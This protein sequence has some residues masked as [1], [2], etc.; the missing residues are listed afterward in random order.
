MKDSF[1][2]SPV[3]GLNWIYE[4]ERLARER[5]MKDATGG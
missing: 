5:S 3:I 2:S 1:K 4:W